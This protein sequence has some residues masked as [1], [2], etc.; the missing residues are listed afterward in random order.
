MSRTDT[1]CVSPRPGWGDVNA[2]RG[3]PGLSSLPVRTPSPS[4]PRCKPPALFP[5]RSRWTPARLQSAL[6]YFWEG[7]GLSHQQPSLPNSP[8][9]VGPK[10]ATTEPKASCRPFSFWLPPLPPQALT[11]GPSNRAGD[12]H[13][14]NLSHWLP[15]TSNPQ[16]P[17][18]ALLLQKNRHHHPLPVS[19]GY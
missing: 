9:A 6:R 15:A 10:A 18:N 5:R 19:S 11:V 2:C 8:E 16:L 12:R 14:P 17:L 3:P 7:S 4:E 1:L 13:D